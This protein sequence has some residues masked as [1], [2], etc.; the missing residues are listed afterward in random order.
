MDAILSTKNGGRYEN[1]NEIQGQT[2]EIELATTPVCTEMQGNLKVGEIFQYYTEVS[3]HPTAK[4]MLCYAPRRSDILCRQERD[5]R[6][7]LCTTVNNL[8]LSQ[9]VLHHPSKTGVPVHCRVLKSCQWT[10]ILLMNKLE[11]LQQMLKENT[12]SW[13]QY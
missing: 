4:D 13:C 12:V 11:A 8:L 10:A 6:L 7:S 1:R 5:R 3:G 9:T 2:P